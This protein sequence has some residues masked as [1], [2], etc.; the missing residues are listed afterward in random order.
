M[1]AQGATEQASTSDELS[2]KLS[3]I[4]QQVK[5]S[6]SV[7]ENAKVKANVVQ[8]EMSDSSE[9]NGRTCGCNGTD[10]STI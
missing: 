1:F 7:A 3:Q 4:S 8:E 2:G 6:A 10:E 9:K 5:E